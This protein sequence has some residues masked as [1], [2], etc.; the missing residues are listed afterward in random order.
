M[1]TALRSIRD[2]Q[3]RAA[4][5]ADMLKA[6]AHPLRLRIAAIL[7]QEPRRVGEIAVLLSAPQ[8]IVSQH[9]RILRMSG[10]VAADRHGG[11]ASYSLT[12]PRIR[13]M[14]DCVE[15]CGLH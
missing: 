13:D 1:T 3:D 6:L 12:E 8:A 15:N 2:D 7:C 14:I 11:N 4:Q 5:L 9:L 10:L